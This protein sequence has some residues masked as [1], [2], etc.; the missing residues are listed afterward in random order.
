MLGL[1]QCTAVHQEAGHILGQP[2]TGQDASSEMIAPGLPGG[3]SGI[4]VPPI[5]MALA[6][7][8]ARLTVH[9]QARRP[10]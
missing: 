7:D 8:Q 5:G 3:A 10:I 2:N 9:D 4:G 1:V 6:A